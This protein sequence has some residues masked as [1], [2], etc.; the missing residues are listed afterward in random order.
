MWALG[1]A[2]NNNLNVVFYIKLNKDPKYIELTSIEESKLIKS[3]FPTPINETSCIYLTENNSKIS[4]EICDVNGK[5]IISITTLN[6]KV[7]LYDLLNKD[8]KKG[9]YILKANRK[10]QYFDVKRFC[11]K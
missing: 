2:K 8:I 10:N 11:V 4:L 5:N 9:I 7:Q 3:I 6:N 1:F